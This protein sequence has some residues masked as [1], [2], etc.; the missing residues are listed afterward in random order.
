MPGLTRREILLGAAAAPLAAVP[1]T[2]MGLATTCYMTVWRPRDTYEFLEHCHAL[3]AG[4]IQ[5][6]LAS[7]EPAYIRKL[8]ERLEA[9]GM[10]LEVMIGLPREDPGAFERTVAAAKEAG[11]LCVRAACLGGRRYETFSTL[12]AWQRFVADSKAALTRAVPIVEKHRMPFAIENHKDWTLD[13][14]VALLKSYSSEYLG[15]CLDTGNNLALL[16]DAMAV[17]E[18]LAPWTIST[19]IKDMDVESYRDGF[20]LSEVPLGEGILDLKRV[21]ATIRAARPKSRVTLEM[22]TRNPL[23]IPCL[24]DKYWATFPERSGRYLAR[25]LAM[26]AARKRHQPLPRIDHL[27]RAVQ[28]RLEADNVKQCLYYAREQLGL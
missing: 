9:T 27:D 10:Y 22:I 2:G 3:G 23:Q 25:A 11:A 20:L 6:G 12:E 17:V 24:T 16:D 14:M 8:R 28:L 15:A 13:E 7:T 5:A 26:V 4:G 21:V 19:H 18:G 1:R